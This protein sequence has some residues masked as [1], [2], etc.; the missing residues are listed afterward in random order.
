MGVDEITDGGNNTGAEREL[1]AGVGLAW[2][3]SLPLAAVVRHVFVELIYLVHR[4]NTAMSE[5]VPGIKV[6]YA[7]TGGAPFEPARAPSPLSTDPVA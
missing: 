5:T 3:A 7:Q 4:N 2:T 1:N 6:V